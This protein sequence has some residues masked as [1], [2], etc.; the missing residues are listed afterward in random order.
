VFGLTRPTL[1]LTVSS[2]NTNY[3]ELIDALGYL[4]N[5]QKARIPSTGRFRASITGMAKLPSVAFVMSAPHIA[6][7]G[8][9][10]HSVVA[11]GTYSK[12]QVEISRLRAESCGGTVVGV[13]KVR[14]SGNP[15]IA[16]RGQVNDVILSQVPVLQRQV[17]G[18]TSGNL[19][20]SYGND[21]IRVAYQ[22]LADKG[23]F[24]RYEFSDGRI[25][26]GYVNGKL[27]IRKFSA[28]V[29]GGTLS[30]TGD[31]E[32]GNM[33]LRLSGAGINLAYVKDLFWS[34]TTVGRLNFEGEVTGS[35]KSPI[36]NGS[37]ECE[38]VMISDIGFQHLAA[39]IML[40]RD[41]L[42]INELSIREGEEE[43]LGRLAEEW[44]SLRKEALELSASLRAAR[45]A[46]IPS[47]EEAVNGQLA[48]LGMDAASL[49]VALE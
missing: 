6:Y 14:F 1:A 27:S 20:V 39:N 34:A 5:I 22:G 31:I 11:E 4:N 48:D 37:V 47:L 45:Q 19:Y 25:D 33:N 42:G 24:R 28:R 9:V 44:E 35:F 21:G 17:E 7:D 10:G 32:H 46:A 15:K 36:F 13:G 3:R 29:L 30:G 49:R 38:R 8:W 40:R 23:R 18:K 16:F 41:R 43:D 2:D 12:G 26:L